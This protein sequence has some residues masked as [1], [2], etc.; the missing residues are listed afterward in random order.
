VTNFTGLEVFV[1]YKTNM[2]T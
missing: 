1:F 2:I